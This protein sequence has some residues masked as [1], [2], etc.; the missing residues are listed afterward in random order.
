V[1][2]ANVCGK[3]L[4]SRPLNEWIRW[5]RETIIVVKMWRLSDQQ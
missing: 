2:P 1:I 4:T 5:R 3:R